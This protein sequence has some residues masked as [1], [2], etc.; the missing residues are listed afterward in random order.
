MPLLLCVCLCV[1]R[2]VLITVHAFV[3]VDIFLVTNKIVDS[4]SR[5]LYLSKSR[6]IWSRFTNITYGKRRFI[7]PEVGTQ[8]DKQNVVHVYFMLKCWPWGFPSVRSM[9]G[10]LYQHDT[11]KLVSDTQTQL[12]PF[13]CFLV[14]NRSNVSYS[15]STETPLPRF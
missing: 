8:M 6:S 12:C 10:F 9:S 7:F 4:K 11:F 13:P 2:P 14:F 1:S 15:L 5:H 3:S